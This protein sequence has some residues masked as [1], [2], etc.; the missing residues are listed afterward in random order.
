MTCNCFSLLLSGLLLSLPLFSSAVSADDSDISSF[1][2]NDEIEDPSPFVD[3]KRWGRELAYQL[4]QRIPSDV[5]VTCLKLD[6]TFSM[7][8]EEEEALLDFT[9]ST[10]SVVRAGNYFCLVR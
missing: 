2:A 5:N 6:F 9:P 7:S 4:K 3:K 10:L 1:S 8:A